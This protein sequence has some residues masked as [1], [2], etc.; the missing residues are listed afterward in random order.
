MHDDPINIIVGSAIVIGIVLI[1]V[2]AIRQS[3][4]I[5]QKQQPLPPH[6]VPNPASNDP[7]LAQL[8]T[9][10]GLLTVIMIIMILAVIGSCFH[11]VSGL[12]NL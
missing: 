1:F 11:W 12:I 2:F 3:K 9:I 6:N 4:K 10:S 5:P 7:I 8:K